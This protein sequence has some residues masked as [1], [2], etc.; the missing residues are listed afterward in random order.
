[1]VGFCFDTTPVDTLVISNRVSLL[2][3]GK[4][5]LPS[6]PRL[7]LLLIVLSVFFNIR[8]NILKISKDG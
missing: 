3:F 7:E 8:T 1:M 6:K 5:D 4:G 2:R